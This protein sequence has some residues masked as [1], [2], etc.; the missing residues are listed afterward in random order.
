MLAMIAWFIIGCEIGFWVFILAGLIARYILRMPKTSNVLLIMTPV[1]DFVLLVATVIDLSNGAQA[2]F[3]HGLAGIYLGVSIVYGHK[4]VK[5]ADRQFEYRFAGGE[6]PVKRT[7][8]GAERA[9]EE[10]IGWYQHFLAWLIGSGLLVSI[11]LVIDGPQGMTQFI[12]MVRNWS[13]DSAATI[14]LATLDLFRTVAV[15]TLVL[16]I[17]FLVSFSYTIFPKPEPGFSNRT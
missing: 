2:S 17:D 16:V 12:E 4:M 7:T 1:T 8:Y 3:I 13:E 15:W 5:W 11:I 14:E 10:R 9:R 6:K